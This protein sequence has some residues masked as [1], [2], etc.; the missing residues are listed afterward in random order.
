MEDEKGL[1]HPIRHTRNR[2]RI[3]GVFEGIERKLFSVVFHSS[4][5]GLQIFVQPYAKPP[6]LLSKVTHP[7][8]AVDP[9]DISLVDKGYVTKHIAKYSHA[10][11]GYCHFSQ[12]GKIVGSLVANSAFRLDKS[13]GHLFTIHICNLENFDMVEKT[14]TKA[15]NLRFDFGSDKPVIYKITGWWFDSSNLRQNAHEGGPLVQMDIGGKMQPGALMAPTCSNW[16]D[17]FVLGLFYEPLNI[18]MEDNEASFTLIGGFPPDALNINRAIDFLVMNYPYT[19]KTKELGSAD[20]N[21]TALPNEA[22]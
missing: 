5:K 11:S 19:P 21:P 8:G 2:F 7:A 18:P 16:A 3:I 12:D 22:G 13:V 10:E 1:L 17:Q 9:T 6:G 20:Y 14:D 4:K 15:H